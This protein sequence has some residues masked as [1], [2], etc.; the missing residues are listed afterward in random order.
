VEVRREAVAEVA[1]VL[2]AFGLASGVAVA[3]AEGASYEGIPGEL[4][5][6]DLSPMHL[7]PPSRYD[8][9]PYT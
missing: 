5:P 8:A 7:I 9:F 3:A 4:S 1:A 6:I 2:L